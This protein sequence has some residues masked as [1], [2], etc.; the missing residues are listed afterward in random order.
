VGITRTGSAT[1]TLIDVYDGTLTG[2]TSAY[3]A[4]AV[5]EVTMDAEWS[6]GMAPGAALRVYAIPTLSYFDLLAGCELVLSDGIAKVASFSAGGPEEGSGPGTFSTEAQEF[7]QMEAAGI[8]MLASSGDGGSNPDTGDNGYTSTNMLSA[9]YPA[10]DPNVTG[11]GGTILEFNNSWTDIGEVVWNSISSGTGN[12]TGGGVST[13][14][15]QPSWQTGTGVPTGG[16]RC[17]PDVAA[18]S[19]ATYNGGGTGAFVYLGGITAEGGT[20]LASPVWA[21]LTALINQARANSGRGTIGLLG[22]YLYPLN[23]ATY[24][25]QITSGNNGAY[26]ANASGYNLCTGLGTPNIANI[27]A[28]VAPQTQV[29]NTAT[30]YQA[31]NSITDGQYNTG[32]GYQALYNDTSGNNNTGVGTQ[33]LFSN[34]NGSQNVGI[35]YRTLYANTTGTYNTANGYDSLPANTSGNGNTG[36]GFKSLFLNTVGSQNTA[37]GYRTLFNNSDGQDNTAVGW[38]ALQANTVGTQNTALGSQ[39][40]YGNS[41]GQGNTAAGYQALYTTYGGYNTA[42]GYKALYTAQ[43]GTANTAAGAEALYSTTT[44]SNSTAVGY[45]S[46]YSNTTAGDSTAVGLGA[47][48]T[49]TTVGSQTALGFEALFSSTGASASFNQADGFQALYNSTAGEQDVAA[50]YQALFANTTGEGNL[51]VGSGA[52]S[53]VLE[54]FNNIDIGNQG[55]STDGYSLGS[56]IRI[57]T[58]GVQTQAFIAGIGVAVITGGV[59]VYVA[60]GTGQL[61]IETSSERFKTDIQDMGSAS[62]ALLALRP[63]SFR[64]NP[65]IDASGVPQFGLIAEEVEKVSPDLVVRGPDGRAFSVRYEAVNAMLLNEYRRQHER[66]AKQAAAISAQEQRARDEQAQIDRQKR[67]ILELQASQGEIAARQGRIEALKAQIEAV[68]KAVATK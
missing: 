10:S 61:G 20:S 41:D 36:S 54:G 50:G 59:P 32:N 47:L 28:S 53:Q 65:G 51:A 67:Q 39:A 63:V 14:F 68:E 33:A 25:N 27:V 57:G 5:G 19:I 37:N 24:F 48:Y 8:T 64:Y 9:E 43:A 60:P 55:A 17:V 56:A 22:P 12:A 11:V 4:D 7:S 13:V 46:L 26:S 1:Y 3:Q 49:N 29:G 30:G 40:L 16:Y 62:E 34:I 58:E 15:T 45:Q 21:G 23:S 52:G 66:L 42:A 2:P 6:S 31:L 18:I 35:G 38:N 44:G